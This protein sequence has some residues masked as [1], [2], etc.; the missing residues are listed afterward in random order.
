M[1]SPTK[2]EAAMAR[3]RMH[4]VSAS[5][6]A[7]VC[8]M[9]LPIGVDAGDDTSAKCP[10]GN[11]NPV[12]HTWGYFYFPVEVQVL[13]SADRPV[14][15]VRLY[16]GHWEGERFQGQLKKVRGASSRDGYVR[17]QASVEHSELAGCRDGQP[18]R[19]E[20]FGREHYLLRAK[21][22]EDLILEV[23]HESTPRE[24]IMTCVDQ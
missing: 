4:P 14:P 8:C 13:K 17:I 10:P 7:L 18:Y 16:A 24:V 9:S 19:A 12:S 20:S 23:S 11:A 15:Q 22:C 3:L 2:R 21:G 5:W 1:S 6:V